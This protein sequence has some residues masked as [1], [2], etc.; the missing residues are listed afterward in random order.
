MTSGNDRIGRLHQHP[1]VRSAAA[2]R[3]DY[4]A[5]G[6]AQ[7]ESEVAAALALWLQAQPDGLQSLLRL[8]QLPAFAEVLVVTTFEACAE[9][10]VAAVGDDATRGWAAVMAVQERSAEFAAVAVEMKARHAA[11]NT[12]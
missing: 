3:R 6:V 5:A 2:E 1:L 11:G 8:H 9:A 4:A 12:P 10:L 7:T